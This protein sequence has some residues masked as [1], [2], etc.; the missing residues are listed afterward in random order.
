M[1]LAQ[2][3]TFIAVAEELHFRRAAERL[4]TQPS[5]VS[6]AIQ[7]LESEY[8]T[9]LFIRNS[10]NVALTPAG[11]VLLKKARAAIASIEDLER[12]ARA[13]STTGSTPLKV[14]MVDEGHAEIGTLANAS[15]R[16]RFPDSELTVD[17]LNYDNFRGAF[18]NPAIDLI[19]TLGPG[20]WFDSQTVATVPLFTEGRM[21]VLPSGHGL[22]ARTSIEVAD[23]LDEPFLRYEA[24]LDILD[25]FFF[26]SD[27]RDGERSPDVVVEATQMT[28]LLNHVSQGKGIF[29]V[30][31]GNE[32][33]FPRPDVAYLPV[34]D[35]PPGSVEICRRRSDTRPHVLA[36]ID[37]C[38]NAVN[39]SLDLI[40]GAINATPGT[41]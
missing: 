14:A 33:F 30:T 41:T 35:L 29:T 26:L 2:L 34:A 38:I 11:E 3:E 9:R 7:Q 19:V 1:K 27:L 25:Q 22:A 37:E 13:L 10:R 16:A 15:Y 12:T 18:D 17:A 20:Q 5:A 31:N 36:Y 28:N 23:L 6:T 24:L 40:P 32:R 39:T 4:Y 8:K 21:A